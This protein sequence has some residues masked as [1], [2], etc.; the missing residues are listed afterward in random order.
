[1]AVAVADLA[2]VNEDLPEE[3]LS[4]LP[5]ECWICESPTIINESLTSFRCSNPRCPTKLSIRIKSICQELNILGFGESAIDSFIET[6]NITNP[7]DLFDLDEDISVGNNVGLRASEKIISQILDIKANRTFLLWE[8]VKLQALPGIQTKAQ[9]I[10]TG[11][12]SIGEAFEAIAEGGVSFIDSRLNDNSTDEINMS[13]ISTYKTLMEFEDDITEGV[14]YL[15]IE[16]SSDIPELTVVVSDQ[17]GGDFNTKNEFY[18]YCKSEFKGKYFFNFAG[19]VTKKSTDF[20]IWMGA[21][22]SPARLTSKIKKV[23]R[24]N[25]QGAGIP[26]LTAAQ[27]IDFL[28]SGRNIEEAYDYSVEVNT[29]ADTE[30]HIDLKEDSYGLL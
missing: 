6:Y 12:G 25:E 5:V 14:N 3:F 16:A 18:N 20:L 17:V 22:G 30:K 27:F 29:G 24:Y 21:D 13:S 26:V 11:F 28:N 23:D 1:M 8:A 10:F 9:K 2:S 4:L 19:S 15:N 7:M